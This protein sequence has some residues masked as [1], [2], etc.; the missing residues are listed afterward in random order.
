MKYARKKLPAY[1]VRHCGWRYRIGRVF[2]PGNFLAS[3]FFVAASLFLAILSPV[4]RGAPNVH[5]PD[6]QVAVKLV[7]TSRGVSGPYST[8]FITKDK[9]TSSA[10]VLGT[11]TSISSGHS[12]VIGSKPIW[13]NMPLFVDPYNSAT[14]YASQNPSMTDINYIYRM[15][16]IPVAQWFGNWNL[17]IS[18]DVNNYVSGASAV[19]QVP[20]LVLYNIPIRDCGGYSTGGSSSVSS[21][22]QW[23]AQV[24]AAIG[25]S[26]AVVILEP[27]ALGA[28]DCL[29]TSALQN[30]RYQSLSQAVSLLKSNANTYVY[31]D[32]GTPVWQSVST[33]SQRLKQAGINMA[34][35]FSLNVSYFASNASNQI[36]G[37]SLSSLVDNKHYVVDTSRNGGDHAVG[38]MLCNPSFASLGS[39]PTANTGNSRNDAF[40]WIKIPW[41][42]DG[43]CN[44]SPEPG[45]GYW[46]YAIQLAK[47]AG[48]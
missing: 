6:N 29:A 31:I 20:V 1:R 40:L 19:N 39:L 24:A 7:T 5:A 35:G 27:D 32:A 14:Q 17:N 28:I 13:T 45:V 34:D 42:S 46:S 33:M 11:N 48:W 16:Q 10:A 23:V 37:D 21:Y 47:N 41:E 22:T 9:K 8:K 2:R 3:L 18:S 26:T 38:G 36:Y 44:G 43:P 30:E 15:G 4:V 12:S 25:N